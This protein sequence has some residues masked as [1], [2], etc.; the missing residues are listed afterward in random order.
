MLDKWANFLVKAAEYDIKE[1]GI[2]ECVVAM[3]NSGMSVEKIST[4]LK[5]IPDYITEILALI[6]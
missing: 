1:Q 3:K 5:R 4:I 2:I 6:K